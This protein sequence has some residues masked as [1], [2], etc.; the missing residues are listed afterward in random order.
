MSGNASFTSYSMPLMFDALESA[1]KAVPSP[2]TEGPD[3]S[4]YQSWVSRGQ[5]NHKGDGPEH[6]G[7]GGAGDYAPFMY[8]LAIPSCDFSFIGTPVRR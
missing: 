4:L 3:D 1:A 6:G 7:L 8:Q 5:A 2:F